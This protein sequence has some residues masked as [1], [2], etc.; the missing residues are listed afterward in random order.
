LEKFEPSFIFVVAPIISTFLTLLALFSPS[1]NLSAF[2]SL[3]FG[4]RQGEFRRQDADT[5]TR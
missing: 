3:A 2:A 4:I 1:E 5:L